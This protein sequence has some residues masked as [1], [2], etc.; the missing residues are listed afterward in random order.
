MTGVGVT[1]D[2]G[3]EPVFEAV[4]GRGIRSMSNGLTSGSTRSTVWPLE[5]L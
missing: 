1:S 3:L 5:A 4:S 2:E